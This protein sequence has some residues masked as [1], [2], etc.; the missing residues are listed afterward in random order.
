[1]R[2]L[3]RTVILTAAL[4]ALT[5]GAALAGERMWFGFQ[6]D[7]SFRWE[8]DR[9][10]SLDFAQSANASIIRTTVYWSK[11]APTRPAAPSNPF[12]P[13]YKLD[14]VDELVREAQK[15]GMEVMLTIWGTPKWANGGLPENRMPRRLS[16]LTAFGRALAS[17]YSGRFPGYPYVRFFSV[18]NEPNLGLFL[19]PQYDSKGRSVGPALYARLYRAAYAGL[20][21]GNR[22]ALVA[23]GETSMRGRDRVT[24]RRGQQQTHSPGRFAELVSKARPRL[25]FD[26]WAHHPYPSQPSARPSERVRWPNVSLSSL[27]RFGPALDGWFK[28]KNTPIWITEYGHETRALGRGISTSKQAAYLRQAVSLARKDPRTQMF[29]WFIFRDHAGTPWQS[30]VLEETGRR[31]PSFGAFTGLARLLDARNPILQVKGINTAVRLCAPNLA[32]YSPPGTM[33]GITYRILDRGA[34]LEVAQP[35]VPLTRD[36][37]LSIRTDF[38]PVAG[39]SYRFELDANDPH[40]NTVS[41]TATLVAP[42]PRAIASAP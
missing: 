30:G 40:G 7:P 28:R 26:A 14:D 15:R 25:K 39:R 22:S 38:R 29:I 12:D 4:V 42:K 2:F 11:V 34:L 8:A 17:R 33:I 21:A 9:S 41:R 23:I 10:E 31:K 20:K 32:F 37:C 1:V 24:T 5:P 6:D 36:G 18:W 16:D 19:S 27:D 35:E 3:T 13:A